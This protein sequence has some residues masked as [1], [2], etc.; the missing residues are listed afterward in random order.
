MKIFKH[1]GENGSCVIISCDNIKIA[2]KFI[3][4]KLDS[5]GLKDESLNVFE[6]EYAC[7]QSSLIHIDRGTY[8]SY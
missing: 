8:Y 2:K 6:I 5:I 1:T 3:R 4:S 7:S